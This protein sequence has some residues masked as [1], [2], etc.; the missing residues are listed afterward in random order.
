[1]RMRLQ[2]L[3]SRAEAGSQRIA[4]TP[5]LLAAPALQ[6][7]SLHGKSGAPGL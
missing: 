4:F 1:M 3:S 6:R 5:H 2:A 7:K